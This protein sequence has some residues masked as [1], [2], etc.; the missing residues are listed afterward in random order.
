[1]TGRVL[2]ETVGSTL[3]R[4]RTRR[5]AKTLDQ[6][7]APC[8]PDTVGPLQPAPT[9]SYLQALIGKEAR[10][11]DRVGITDDPA[12]TTYNTPTDDTWE[13]LHLPVLRQ[14]VPAAPGGQTAIARQA[15]I[16]RPTLSRILKTGKASKPAKG[17]LAEIAAE[18][19]TSALQSVDPAIEPAI[20]PDQ[21]CHEYLT[22]VSNRPRG[23]AECGT[24][25][26]GRQTQ[27]CSDACRKKATRARPRAVRR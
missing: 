14:L 25:L 27:W 3:E 2:I 18:L 1:M 26:G 9:D 24:A 16:A 6:Q 15:V 12:T 13:T 19:S 23:C 22:A 8:G 11:L 17:R 10:N 4:N 20:D 7:G 21:R 5:D